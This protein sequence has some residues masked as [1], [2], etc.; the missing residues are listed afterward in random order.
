MSFGVTI[1]AQDVAFTQYY[2][3]P[4]LLNPSLVGAASGKFRLTAIN[5]DQWGNVLVEPFSTFGASMDVRFNAGFGKSD[6]GDL[7]GAGISFFKDKVTGLDFSTTRMTFYGAY[8]KL[9]D[10]NTKQYLSGGLSIGINTQNVNYD[11]LFFGDQF[12]G[13][14]GFDLPTGEDDNPIVNNI[15]YS[16][17]AVGFNY[18]ISP[19][20]D[21]SIHSGLAIHHVS[22]PSN[23]FYEDEEE[24]GESV[25]PRK[26]TIHASAIMR[27]EGDVSVIPR[28]IF[29]SQGPHNNLILGS[30]LRLGIKN[31]AGTAIQLGLWVKPSFQSEGGVNLDA[32]TLLTGLEFRSL[33]LGLSYDLHVSDINVAGNQRGSFELSVTYTGEDESEDVLCPAF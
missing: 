22:E 27:M 26:I 33:I 5:R 3:A 6:N 32:I 30:N 11:A 21:L 23:T 12:N 2:A 17:I 24:P 31:T 19:S 29:T 16:D 14:N 18:T 15:T 10:R 13:T 7:I 8:H 20:K 1:Q 4:L 9:L 25:V 28:A